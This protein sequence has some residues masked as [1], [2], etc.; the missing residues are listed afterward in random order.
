MVTRTRKVLIAID[1]KGNSF[2]EIHRETQVGDKWYPDDPVPLELGSDDAAKWQAE[3]GAAQQAE[4]TS[5]KTSLETLT[6]DHAA[7]LKTIEQ[8]RAAEVALLNSQIAT[9]TTDLVAMTTE[10]NRWRDKSPPEREV[11]TKELIVRIATASPDAIKKI[12]SSDT[13]AAAF[14]TKTLFAADRKVDLN[15]E[16]L[17]EILNDLVAAEILTTAEVAKIL[18]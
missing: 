11:G 8:E 17:L 6:A 1:D 3:F 9:L 13:K 18:E 12:W 2:A 15:S 16:V 5:L 4:N 14:A 10:R 7:A